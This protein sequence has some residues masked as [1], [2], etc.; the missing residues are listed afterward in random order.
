MSVAVVHSR[1]VLDAAQLP[2]LRERLVR[3]RWSGIG[4]ADWE[5]GVPESWLQD[6][7]ADEDWLAELLRAHGVEAPPVE[8][9][10]LPYGVELSDRLRALVTD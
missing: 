10:R 5:L 3:S 8:L 9:R 2:E 7:V 1:V 6:L 4:A